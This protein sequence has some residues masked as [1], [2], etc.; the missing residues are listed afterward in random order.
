MARKKKATE[1]RRVS[2]APERGAAVVGPATRISAPVRNTAV[3]LPLFVLRG[4]PYDGLEAVQGQG[5]IVSVL[6]FPT[7]L[8]VQGDLGFAKYRIEGDEAHH[9]EE[10]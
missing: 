8:H 1:P 9:V 2:E 4:G 3:G 5:S 10:I 6:Y 7:E